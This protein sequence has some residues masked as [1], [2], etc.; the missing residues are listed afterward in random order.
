MPPLNLDGTPFEPPP[1]Q[2]AQPTVAA[3]GRRPTYEELSE[4]FYRR[5]YAGLAEWERWRQARRE[6]QEQ[7]D[8]DEKVSEL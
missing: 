1:I 4:A 8:D 3:R 7:G 2:P 5:W 6:Q